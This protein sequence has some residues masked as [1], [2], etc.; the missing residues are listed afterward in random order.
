MTM[1]T[2]TKPLIVLALVSVATAVVAQSTQPAIDYDWT[3]PV[4]AQRSLQ[5]A[6]SLGD[7]ATISSAYFA[8]NDDERALLDSMNVQGEASAELHQA[9]ITKF[10]RDLPK[11][12]AEFAPLDPNLVEADVRGDEAIVYPAGKASGL[13]IKWIRVKGEWKVAMSD[14]LRVHLFGGR[15]LKSAIDENHKWAEQLCRLSRDIRAGHFTSPEEVDRKLDQLAEKSNE[16]AS[17][18]PSAK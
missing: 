13:W 3:T 10:A 11:P 7:E 12:P 9:C 1:H 2:L 17:T 14:V 8:A 18:R 4:A 15:T 6:Q 5:R 16:P